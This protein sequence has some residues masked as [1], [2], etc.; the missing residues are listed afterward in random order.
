MILASKHGC[1]FLKFSQC[2]KD[3]KCVCKEHYIEKFGKCQF[4][5]GG[6]C[7]NVFDCGFN[8]SVCQSGKCQCTDEFIFSNELRTCIKLVVLNNT[9]SSS[10]ESVN[11]TSEETHSENYGNN[12][13]AQST[14]CSGNSCND[15]E[16][17]TTSSFP[18]NTI[19]L[20]TELEPPCKNDEECKVLEPPNCTPETCI[21]YIGSLCV[22]DKDCGIENSHCN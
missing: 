4:S 16:N 7:K 1:Q 18:S 2:S 12:R 19:E 21:D 14:P 3:K 11:G 5:V 13:N 15:S 17:V 20:N 8:N 10:T 22:T 9:E 6:T